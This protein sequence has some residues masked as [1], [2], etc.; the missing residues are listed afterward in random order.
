MAEAATIEQR[1]EVEARQRVRVVKSTCRGCHGACGVL[2]HVR[3]GVV[4]KVA[5]DPDNP[6]NRGSLCSIGLAAPELL[7]HQ[8]RLLQPMKRK[9]ARGSG[10]WQRISWDEAFDT[11]TAK[12]KSLRQA[13]GAES[14]CLVQGT[15]R[16]YAEFLY[17]F[18]NVF[19]TPSVATPGYL[20]YFPRV[21]VHNAVCGGL[22][23]ANYE[24]HPKCAV[25][26]GCNPHITSPEEYQGAQLVDAL[27][28]GMKLVVIDPRFTTLA[29][30]ATI[31]L[32]LRP[33]TD[34]ALALG[35][36]HHIIS[37]ELY[38]RDFVENYAIGFEQLAERARQW[39]LDRVAEITW[40]PARKIADA[41]EL[42][43]RE[44]PAAI[45]PGQVLDG[46]VNAAANAL[47][48][49][50]LMALTGNLD[51]KG[52][53]VLFSPPKVKT[54][55][56]FAL[57]GELPPQAN[58]KRLGGSEFPVANQ[59]MITTHPKLLDSILD[60]TPYRTRAVL[61]H[62]SNALLSWPDS[63]RVYKAFNALEFLVVTELF[64]TPTAEL[65]DIVLPVATW[66]ETDDVAAYWTRHGMVSVRQK[67]VQC[68]EVKSDQEIL[69]ELGKR[70]GYAEKFFATMEDALSDLLSPSGLTWQQ[71][72]EVAFLPGELRYEKYRTRG[73][74]TP[75]RKY[76]FVPEK[77]A[78]MGRDPLPTYLEPPESPVSKPRLA[79]EY[80]LIL[81]T[82]YRQPMFFHS[83]SRQI[84]S[85]RSKWP[86]PLLEVHPE[87]A[88]RYNL[89]D[90]AM[91]VIESPRGSISM[92]VKV[93]P[94]VLRG[95]VAAPHCWWFPEKTSPDH[96]WR[97]A[98]VNML[99]DSGPPYDAYAGSVSIRTLLC[100]VRP[101]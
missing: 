73:F 49:G 92:K 67:I 76:E 12:L 8:D 18:A 83:E 24:A 60:G 59:G 3:D 54:L 41:A 1:S 36:I 11:I 80:P 56:Q 52:G 94:G 2:V 86:E 98:N 6:M 75:S 51:R 70:L 58:A 79:K 20:C 4:T 35:M 97:E 82:G 100:R 19:G 39:P 40:L 32:Q 89:Q 15:G 34:T 69:M 81:S 28:A 38:D 61:V 25:I 50:H 91:A 74:S 16:D 64:M 72:K 48:L 26:W 22:P 55:S 17:R 7:Y 21:V 43:A 13:H 84:P 95:M 65:A 78:A 87:T 71:F 77:I 42:Y 53:N 23:I 101:A 30:R 44:K 99:T 62:G 66:L 33:G 46:S 9:G 88:A 93:T 5:G 63:Q 68:G 37:N 10:Q 27:N 45:N 85:L 96:G 29:S 47:C 31:W 90:G 14:V 57:H